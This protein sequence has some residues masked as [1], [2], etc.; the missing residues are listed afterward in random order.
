MALKIFAYSKATNQHRRIVVDQPFGV[1]YFITQRT[2]H[3]P[4]LD[5]T[6]RYRKHGRNLTRLLVNERI[7]LSEK[8]MF[9]R[10]C[11][12]MEKFVKILVS[13]GKNRQARLDLLF[14]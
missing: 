14:L 3:L 11:I 9:I 1:R 8:G 5:A 6:V 12:T 13:T 10:G 7:S 4:S 2:T